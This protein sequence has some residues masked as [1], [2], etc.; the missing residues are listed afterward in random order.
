MKNPSLKIFD[1]HQKYP[2]AHVYSLNGINLTINSQEKYG[3]LGPNGAGKTTLIS[4][5]C[6]VLE[7]TTG[8]INYYSKGNEISP[9][10]FQTKLGY[11]PQE[12]A[13]YEELTPIQNLDFFGAMYG[14]APKTIR[15][16]ANAV[17][18]RIGLAEVAHKKVQSFSGGM[19]R[20]VNLAI[21]IIH[22][23]E[24]LI[25]DEPTVGVDIQSKISILN[26]LDE[27]NQ[28]GTTIIYTSHHLDEAQEFCTRIA[29]LD[30][31][32][33]VDEGATQELLAK[34]NAKTLKEL[35]ISLSGNPIH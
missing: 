3:I 29:F 10:E 30:H 27:L 5:I 24:V 21:G 16:K 15:D 34:H 19:K 2:D 11:V 14:L 7:A 17:L 20:K 12:Y 8:E 32:N 25:L 22:N 28:A 26:F 35:F 31:G 1:V 13:F 4:I 18:E 23:P 9:N 6:R 33:I